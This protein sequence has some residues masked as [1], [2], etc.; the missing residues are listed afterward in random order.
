VS[1]SIAASVSTKQSIVAKRGEIMPAPLHCALSRTAPEG[2]CTSRLA[3]FSNASVVSIA[4]WKSR[5]AVHVQAAKRAARMPSRTES[6]GRWWLMLPVEA[7]ATRS[8]STPAARAAATL[9][10]GGVLEPAAAGRGVRA[11]RVHQ[12]RPKG[13]EAAAL[14]ADQDGR[15]GRARCR[16]AGRAD[17]GIGDAHEQPDVGVPALLDPGRDARRAKAAGQPCVPG[18]LANVRGRGHP[19]RAERTAASRSARALPRS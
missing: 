11:P 9:R 13:V 17:G 14:E 2:S 16:E 7:M 3:R 4:R 6:T 15:G 5:V 1:A 18:Q 19:A 10:L 8:G 12:H